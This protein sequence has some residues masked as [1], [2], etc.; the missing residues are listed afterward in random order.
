MND[1]TLL[2][3]SA[4][5]ISYPFQE[6]VRDA[7]CAA[8]GIGQESTAA[9]VEARMPTLITITQVPTSWGQNICVGEIGASIYNV[10]RQILIG[11]KAATTPFVACVEDDSLYTAEHFTFRPPMDTFAYNR[12]RWVITRKLSEDGKSR[13]AFY[14]WR[15]RT[16]MAQCIC[17]REL[18]IETLEE[19]FAAYPVPPPS[20][21]V[22]K[23]AGW[24][25]PGRYEKNLRLTPRKRM[26]FDTVQPNVTFN[27]SVSLM[28]RRRVNPDDLICA[29]LPPWGDATALWNRIHG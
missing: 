21:D 10:Y 28:G 11:A 25:E 2:Y 3:Y 13:E 29:D 14:Y 24:G 27:H 8:F 9:E 20:T 12:N 17:S 7:L 18:L 23:K 22:A 26:Y 1:L 4:N 19:K 6:N 5:R 16:Q 15:E